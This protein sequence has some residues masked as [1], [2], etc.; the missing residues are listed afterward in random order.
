MTSSDSGFRSEYL[1]SGE[2][3]GLGLSVKQ[4]W[5]N[6]QFLRIFSR[7]T[8]SELEFL[9]ISKKG[10]ILAVMPVFYKK[11]L[12]MQY[13]YNPEQFFYYPI[14]Y[15]FEPKRREQENAL[16]KQSINEEIA[17]SL[18]S[19]FKHIKIKLQTEISDLR[20]FSWHGYRVNPNYTLEIDLAK[21]DLAGDYSYN[22]Q[23]HIKKAS[24]LD[25]EF[26]NKFGTEEVTDLLEYTYKKKSIDYRA[27]LSVISSICRDLERAGFLRISG[28]RQGG[29]LSAIR[30]V[31]EDA[32]NKTAY[33]WNA[34]SDESAYRSGINSYLLDKVINYYKAELYRS[35]DLCGANIKSVARFKH[36]F[37]SSLRVFYSIYKFL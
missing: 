25:P 2:L 19:R 23:Q 33:D 8:N 15:Y 31:I 12:W 10:S 26:L 14:S 4:V 6:P 34:A 29:K 22:Q 3:E 24:E 16:L 30:L 35:Y 9:C 37:G 5:S 20:A 18:V 7:N 11:K 17:S 13:L 36:E 1:K 21:E 27:R 28:I 32:E